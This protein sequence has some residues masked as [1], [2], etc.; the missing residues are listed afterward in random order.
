MGLF[1]DRVALVTSAGGGIGRALSGAL[2]A[3]G[4]RAWVVGR[5]AEPLSE[6]VAV[7][8][9]D[10]VVPVV[11]DLTDDETVSRLATDVAA[12]HER[13][14]IFVHCAGTIDHG[15]IEELAVARLDAQYRT[16]VRMFYVLVQALLP[17]LRRGHGQIVVVNS[18]I[19]LGSRGGTG[20]Y[21]STQHALRAITDTLRHEVNPDGIRVLSVYPGRTATSRQERLFE[22]EERDYRPELLLQPDDVAAVVVNALALQPTAEVTDIYLRPMLKSY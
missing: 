9:D 5:S 2:V 8:G 12:A 15:T 11:C 18:S 21:A 1:D 10:R 20:Q 17:L 14:D 6:T 4:A 16:N 22:K 7:C 13:L 19:V 3:E